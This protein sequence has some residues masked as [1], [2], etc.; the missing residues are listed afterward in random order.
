MGTDLDLGLADRL[1]PE[2]QKLLLGV[3][4]AF[5]AT[6]KRNL[7]GLGHGQLVPRILQD[8]AAE[9]VLI[10]D[11]VADPEMLGL[12]R[13][14]EPGRTT[15]NDQNA[16]GTRPSGVAPCERSRSP[17]VRITWLPCC[18][19]WRISAMTAEFARDE[20]ARHRGLQF[21]RE[22][23]DIGSR[24]NVAQPH[25]QGPYRAHLLAMTVAD[26]VRGT[27]QARSALH[28]GQNV[29]LDAGPNATE[30][31]QAQIGIDVRVL[32]DRLLG[33]MGRGLLQL[34]QEPTILCFSD[35]VLPYRLRR[36]TH[37]T[38]KM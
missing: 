38:G 23:G 34:R 33:A 7:D 8:G 17:M 12:Q 13:R 4:R 28:D 30:T 31:P 15:A 1:F 3:L 36:A 27:H 16:A 25:R 18:I 32:S 14:R 26:A 9:I 19:A 10:D 6:E 5:E 35:P 2:A 22:H 11:H 24:L 20:D 21:R 37:R 29:A